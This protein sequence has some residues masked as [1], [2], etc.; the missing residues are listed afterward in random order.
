[1]MTDKRLTRIAEDFRDGLLNGRHSRLM[2]FAV[3]AP[4][5]SL[6]SIS[7]IETELVEVE[8]PGINHFYLRLLD[9]RILDPTADQFDLPAVYLGPVP[10]KYRDM[11]VAEWVR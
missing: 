3:C 11:T 10:E 9:G 7:G 2:C 1:M 6:L 5:Q 4:L 8:F